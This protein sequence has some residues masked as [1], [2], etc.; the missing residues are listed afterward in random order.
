MPLLH[1]PQRSSDNQGYWQGALCLY[2]DKVS[3]IVEVGN[4]SC[5]VDPNGD[6]DLRATVSLSSDDLRVI[7]IVAQYN[8][9]DLL[10]NKA[11]RRKQKGY[12]GASSRLYRMKAADVTVAGEVTKRTSDGDVYLYGVSV[13]NMTSSEYAAYREKFVCL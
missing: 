7:P 4:D 1:D 13:S 5:R 10:Y 8:K 9:G 11:E 12:S 3:M 6:S 2:K